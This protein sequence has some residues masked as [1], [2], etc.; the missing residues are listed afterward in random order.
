M[1]DR[2]S[3]KRNSI[4]RHLEML[5]MMRSRHQMWATEGPDSEIMQTHYDII[6]LIEQTSN[7]YDELLKLYGSK[8]E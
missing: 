1:L 5:E 6:D 3:I 7:K 4:L 8:G 2:N